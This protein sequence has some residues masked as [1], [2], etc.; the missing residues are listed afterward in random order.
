MP[1]PLDGRPLFQTIGPQQNRSAVLV[2]TPNNIA[3][4]RFMPPESFHNI[5]KI[6]SEVPDTAIMEILDE[7]CKKIQSDLGENHWGLTTEAHSL[8]YFRLFLRA[9]KH[10][11]PLHDVVS[12][13]AHHIEFYKVTIA[14]LLKVEALPPS[15]LERFER[16]FA[17]MQQPNAPT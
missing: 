4:P 12:L 10:E 11:H 17:V 16:T 5:A 3:T 15:T 8:L 9:A 14:R 2:D 1:W 13:P 7:Q 6:I